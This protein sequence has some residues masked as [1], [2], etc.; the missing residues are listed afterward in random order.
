MARNIMVEPDSE[1]YRGSFAIL[2]APKPKSK[3]VPRNENEECVAK[4]CNSCPR[5]R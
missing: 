5:E 1:F 4:E 3:Y 2:F